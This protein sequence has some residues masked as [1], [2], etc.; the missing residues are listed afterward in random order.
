MSSEFITKV[1][2]RCNMLDYKEITNRIFDIC[3]TKNQTV[4]GKRMGVSQNLVS[5][6]VSGER[7][8]TLKGLEKLVDDE[9]LNWD[10]LL[11]G[12]EPKY[13]TEE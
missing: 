10:W 11:E 8:P 5:M 13:R 7:K 9:N 3:G 1:L 4:V 12:R 6:W 2:E